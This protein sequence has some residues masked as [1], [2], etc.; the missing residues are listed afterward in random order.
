M[1]LQK[2]VEFTSKED[3]TERIYKVLLKQKVI[4]DLPLKQEIFNTI[5]KTK[6]K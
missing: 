1:F 6:I 2:E 3:L 5:E 4:S